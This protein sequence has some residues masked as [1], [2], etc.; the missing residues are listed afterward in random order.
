MSQIFF[1]MVRV[2]K[3]FHIYT[4]LWTIFIWTSSKQLIQHCLIGKRKGEH[5]LTWTKVVL[6][7]LKNI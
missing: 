4:T 2:D 7:E 6:K 3:I 5:V 1:K